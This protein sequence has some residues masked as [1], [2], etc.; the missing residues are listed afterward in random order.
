MDAISR[1][2]FETLL[3]ANKSVAEQVAPQ[4]RYVV[5]L[6]DGGAYLAGSYNGGLRGVATWQ[7]SRLFDF[8]TTASM[9]ALGELAL[10]PDDFTVEQVSR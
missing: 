1:H 2:A 4:T 10:G 6:A 7:E 9:W 5:R 8:R 3:A